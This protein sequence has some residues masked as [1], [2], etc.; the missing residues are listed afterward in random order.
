M[1][2]FEKINMTFGEIKITACLILVD[3]K[4]RLKSN[5]LCCKNETIS[6]I[7]TLVFLC[8]KCRQKGIFNNRYKFKKCLFCNKDIKSRYK[9]CSPEC[10]YAYKSNSK[11]LDLN[12]QKEIRKLFKRSRARYRY[13]GINHL[14][15][16]IVKTQVKIEMGKECISKDSTSKSL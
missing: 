9:F 2:Y 11:S 13:Y 4:P 16:D 10:S 3:G 8:I 15:I 6:F 12:K 14:P 5:C 7:N 1:T